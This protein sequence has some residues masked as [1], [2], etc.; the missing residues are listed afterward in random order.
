[1]CARAMAIR[2]LRAEGTIFLYRF[3]IEKSRIYDILDLHKIR[4][5]GF[6]AKYVL[7]LLYGREDRLD[8]VVV[9]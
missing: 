5:G 7:I 2:K 3:R 9:N 1:M 4:R 6:Y 8:R